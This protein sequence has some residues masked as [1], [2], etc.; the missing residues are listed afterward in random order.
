MLSIRQLELVKVLTLHKHFGHAANA[1][2]ISQP[3]LSK[4]ISYIEKLLGVTLFERKAQV[5]PTVFG[6]IVVA[7]SA[8]I[9]R[10]YS[11]MLRELKLV[12][13]LDVGSL[14]ISAGLHPSS[15]SVHLALGAL[16]RDHPNLI[17]NLRVKDWV[18]VQEDVLAR[19]CDLGVAEI[20]EAA[21]HAELETEPLRQSPLLLFSR[22]G[23]PV[24]KIKKLSLEDTLEYPWVG[25]S[26]PS[27]LRAFLSPKSKPFGYFDP[28][29][30]RAVPRIKVATMSA[31]KD[32]VSNGDAI[33]AAPRQLIAKEIADGR[34]VPLHLE[35]PWLKLNYGF[36]W[37]RDRSASPSM[38]AF[39]EIVRKIETGLGP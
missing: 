37:R 39:M 34:V 19:N 8:S 18:L 35:L 22:V 4:G 24:T 26:L 25:T 5:I 17:C 1:L 32:I 30:N 10:D 20:T 38:L 28:E 13:G 6:E 2:G 7:H 15:M 31:I 16:S 27:A 9:I 12:E 21:K 3:A 29:T 33:S 11:E 14:M 23:H 36:M